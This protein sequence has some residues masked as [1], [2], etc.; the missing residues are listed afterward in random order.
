MSSDRIWR[1]FL[2][3]QHGEDGGDD[4]LYFESQFVTPDFVAQDA[5]E[6]YWNNHDGWELGV[7][8]D[9]PLVL[10]APDGALTHWTVR[11][12]QSVNFTSSPASSS[13]VVEAKG[14]DQ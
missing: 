13:G 2:P 6:D 1:Y 7:E 11:A 5:L 14:A 9:I 8:E 12:E 3:D 4:P 10:I